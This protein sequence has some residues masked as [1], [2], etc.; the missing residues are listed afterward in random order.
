MKNFQM[1]SKINLLLFL[2]FLVI[3][4]QAQIIPTHNRIVWTP[5]IPGGIPETTTWV[6]KDVVSDFGADNSGT[7]D[8]L[9]QIQTGINN[10]PTS[11]NYVIQFPMGTY[12]ME[13]T[14]VLKDNMV[15]RG[16][17]SE[18]K[19]EFYNPT[20]GNCI[21]IL[22]YGYGVWQTLATTAGYTKGALSLSVPNP[23]DFTVGKFAE[24]QQTNSAAMNDWAGN[25]PET[26]GADA[27]GQLFEVAAVNGNL[28][29]FKTPLH[30]SYNTSLNPKIRAMDFISNVGIE[31]MYL[32]LKT[33]TDV[34]M[35][36]FRNSAYCWVKNVVSYKTRKVHVECSRTLG[37]E[38]KNSVFSHSYNYEGG[39]GYGIASGTHSSDL[40]VENNVF[41]HLRHAMLFQH[42]A[43]GNVFAYNHSQ[44]IHGED[45]AN[46]Y[47]Y[48]PADIS[49]HGV[50]GYMNLFESN[51]V[52]DIG[53][54]DAWGPVG[55][56]N[57]YFR[58]HVKRTQTTEGLSYWDNN[59]WQNVIG[60]S[61]VR[62]KD[63]RGLAHDNIEHGN[64]IDGE[65]V[66]D[67]NIA[68]TNLPDSYYLTAKPAFLGSKP[69]PLFGPA[70]GYNN[71]LPAKDNFTPVFEDDKDELVR[72]KGPN[73]IA[74]GQTISI[75]VDYFA[76][77]ASKLHIS[78]AD[79]NGHIKA[80]CYEENAIPVDAGHGT[81]TCE[82]LVPSSFTS[83]GTYT[84]FLSDTNAPS[85]F[86]AIGNF[87]WK[88][89]QYDVIVSAILPVQLDNFRAVKNNKS[90]DLFWETIQ[91]TNNDF[92]TVERS[93]DGYRF[94]IIGKVIGAGNSDR[95]LNY[96]FV[97]KA[98]KLGINYYR[99]T[100]TDFDGKDESFD[101][102]NV[103]FNTT[104]T[105]INPT[106]VQDVLMLSLEAKETNGQVVIFNLVGQKVFESI[107]R[108]GMKNF[109]INAESFASGPY[110]VRVSN[111]N[112]VET[113]RFIKH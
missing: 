94:E 81:V 41:D 10:L 37:C 95:P 53:I 8:A 112:N 99:L 78:L 106:L 68:E 64:V 35:I 71:Q 55:P 33:D 54:S 100:Q 4:A 14:L 62:I 105:T 1:N 16:A 51:S 110:F 57:T 104:A 70:V 28:V 66:W 86:W 9:T 26:W 2:M 18:T 90:V 82:L 22:K 20:G 109:E 111:G 84:A 3:F 45:V 92:F 58:N 102:V 101:V 11:A 91:E 103:E 80:G 50:Y 25:A 108:A 107:I 30:L 113:L 98:P 48:Y 96:R 60:N 49:G 40:L 19:L 13:G 32:T 5:G 38:V 87:I 24:I 67:A 12:K 97:D 42:G 6:V 29:T 56:G 75:E 76:K 36:S 85:P 88:L 89:N 79:D 65:T 21:T 34:S 31:D 17:G 23:G 77:Q 93:D 44:R 7:T 39:H 52:N 46:N 27:I 63:V 15:L 83:A 69:W 61:V 43:N 73:K 72:V 47:T 59:A 74:F